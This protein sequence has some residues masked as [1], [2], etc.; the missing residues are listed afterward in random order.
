MCFFVPHFLKK[1]TIDHNSTSEYF[2]F[3][4]HQVS[5][6]QNS[7]HYLN[8]RQ[9][10]RNA[11]T[12]QLTKMDSKKRKTGIFVLFLNDLTTQGDDNERYHTFHEGHLKI[13][14]RMWIIPLQSHKNFLM[15]MGSFVRKKKKKWMCTFEH[16]YF[17]KKH[18]CVLAYTCSIIIC[19][20]EVIEQQG[21]HSA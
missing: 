16:D 19:K 3:G 21:R 5:C 17:K 6:F 12:S 8:L 1:I 18:E 4:S 20:Q 9:H 2:S 13:L 10:Q 7:I 14:E 15:P 11:S